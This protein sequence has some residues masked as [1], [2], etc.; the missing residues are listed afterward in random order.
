MIEAHCNFTGEG[1]GSFSSLSVYTGNDFGVI[2]EADCF[3]NCGI[4]IWELELRLSRARMESPV[5]FLL[6][7][8]S[9]V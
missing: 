3:P 2:D 4:A 7:P 8:T 6:L 9:S 1:L 5:Y